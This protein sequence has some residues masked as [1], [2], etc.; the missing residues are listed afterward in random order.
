[1][2]T[3][4]LHGHVLVLVALQVAGGLRLVAQALH[5]AHDIVGLRQ[6]GITEALHPHRVLAEGRQQLRESHQRLHTRVPGLL[7]HLFDRIVTRGFGVGLGPGHGFT[8]LP[9]V[10]GRHQYLGQQCIGVQ[11]NRRQHLVQLLLGEDRVLGRDRFA[12]RG[13]IR[14]RYV[15]RQRQAGR[16]VQAQERQQESKQWHAHR[17]SP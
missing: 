7:R 1:M 10:S 8:H 2:S 13:R 11:S 14:R 3:G 17:F 4:G 5:G 16:G 6:E 9:R 15:L 12:L